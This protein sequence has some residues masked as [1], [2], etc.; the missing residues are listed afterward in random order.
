MPSGNKT[1]PQ[2]R[3]EYTGLWVQC[4]ECKAW[5]HGP[6]VG[7]KKAPKSKRALCL[8]DLNIH[9]LSCF[10]KC[11]Q[12]HCLGLHRDSALQQPSASDL[13]ENTFAPSA[14]ERMQLLL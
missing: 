11:W 10:V 7:L 14:S 13:Q 12:V 2:L 9:F 4:D 3:G 8:I 5:L 1:V 6:C